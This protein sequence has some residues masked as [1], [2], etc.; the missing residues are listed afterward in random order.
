MT[1]PK[2]L[3]VLVLLV[4]VVVVGCKSGNNHSRCQWQM[5]RNSS[6]RKT[7]TLIRTES[8]QPFHRSM[9][10]PRRKGSRTVRVPHS[11]NPHTHTH[12]HTRTYT[13]IYIQNHNHDPM[14]TS[15]AVERTPVE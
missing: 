12:T 3:L 4:L 8:S 13:H 11:Q 2:T 15:P 1:I 10:T 14:I 5:A 6:S 9:H 7:R